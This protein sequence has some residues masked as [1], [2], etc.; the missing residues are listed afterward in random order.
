M[1]YSTI[2]FSLINRAKSRLLTGYGENHHIIPKC[3]GGDD[4]PNNLVKLTAREH[5]IA[6]LLLVKLYPTNLKLVKAVAM[7]CMGQTERKLT[8][9]LY[10]K[11]RV[12]FSEA[13]A[14][15]Q[16]GNK[17]SQY[18]SIWIHNIKTLESKKIK[19]SEPLMEGWSFGRTPKGQHRHK[20]NS[21]KIVQQE[22]NVLLHRQYY[23]IYR[24]VGFEEFV[25]ITGYKK[26]KQNLVQR[27]ARLLDEFEP[28]NGKRRGAKSYVC[29]MP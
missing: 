20:I 13:M 4:S 11:I 9:R 23:K 24:D 29:L 22:E 10:G 14:E 28:Q 18:G 19:K 27:F 17:N 8:N 26:S 2:Y 6:H 7:M 12:R 5:F 15:S 1:N 3:L 25:K 16:R 21:A